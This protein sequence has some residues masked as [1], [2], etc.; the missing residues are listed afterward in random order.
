MRPRPLRS[1]SS[2]QPRR[3]KRRSRGRGRGRKTAKNGAAEKPKGKFLSVSCKLPSL[4]IPSLK[5]M[6]IAAAGLL[7]VVG[8]GGGAYFYFFKGATAHEQK[9]V[10]CRGQARDLRRSARR[11]GQSVECRR[12]DRTQYLKV[13]IVLEVPNRRGGDPDPAADAARD[14][15]LPDLFA[16]IAADRSRR[17]RRPLPAQGGIDPPGQ[18]RGRSPTA[19]PPFCSRRSSF[20]KRV[21]PKSG[22]GFRKRSCATKIIWRH[23]QPGR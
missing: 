5:M 15:R 20:S 3:K 2:W 17:L 18:R 14:G 22:Y 21:I 4:K 16:R 1:G 12:S 19:S 23:T 13:K 9:P 7:V 8:G 11:A 6:I 10:A